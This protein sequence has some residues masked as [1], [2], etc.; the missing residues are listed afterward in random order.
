MRHSVIRAVVGLLALA[1]PFSVAADTVF[2]LDT[3]A[4]GATVSGIV[5]VSGWVADDGQECGPPP[6]W[7]ACDWADALVSNIDL[8][9]D[10]VFVAAADLNVPR[11]DVLQAYPWY[12]GTPFARPG[13]STSFDADTLSNG[14]HSLFVRITFSDGSS[15]DFGTRTFLVDNSINQA[16]FGEL[17]L[18]GAFQPMNGVFPVTGWALDDGSIEDIEV[19]VDGLVVG[20][21]VAGIHRPD[22]GNRFPWHPGAD[23]AGF[24]RML[25]TTELT[26]GVHTLAVRLRDDDGATRLVGRRFVQ[27]ANASYNLPPFGA[28]DW[29][30]ANHY[31]LGLGCSE[32]GG[33]STPPFE[34][35]RS[36]EFI[37][38]W[39]L[40]VGSSTDR[41]GVKY[42]QLLINGSL[43][44]D[45]LVDSFYY[46]WLETYV[47]YY[48]KERLDVLR[49]FPDVP[50]AKVSGFM[51]AVDVADLIIRRGFHRGLHYLKIRAGDLENNVADIAQIPVIFDCD[52]DYDRASFGDIYAPTNM[53]RISDTFEVTGWAIDLDFVIEVEVWVDGEFMGYADTGILTPE[54]RDQFPW[55]PIFH[56]DDAGY[57][58]DLDTTTISEGEHL[59]AIRT[60]DYGGHKNFV[61]ERSFV[62]DNLNK[63]MVM[64]R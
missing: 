21:A 5:E 34:E 14:S 2:Q 8:Y 22:I 64:S 46:D 28:I 37:T 32:P 10:G 63:A 53:E 60:V 49:M 31:M 59:L 15:E 42:V 18:P 27:T 62:V 11:Y 16:P 9:V 48:G 25:N 41:G 33:F 1:L 54:V 38:G 30:I 29:P 35:P 36:V 3:P 43:I 19:L 40:D 55:L 24:I 26:N 45:T 44:A 6:E 50:N 20:H 23:Y 61:G 4:D 58:F 7:Q 52:D 13:F 39:A 51:F 56:T 57:S 12:A 47:N 17:E